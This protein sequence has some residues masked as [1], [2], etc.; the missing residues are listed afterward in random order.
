MA[1]ATK[2]IGNRCICICALLEKH[3]YPK[4]RNVD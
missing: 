3:E 1:S 2:E 4:W